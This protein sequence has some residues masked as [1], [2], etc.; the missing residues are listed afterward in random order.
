MTEK[1]AKWKKTSALADLTLAFQGFKQPN[2]F[3]LFKNHTNGIPLLTSDKL[4]TFVWIV[5]YLIRTEI[6]KYSNKIYLLTSSLDALHQHMV[7]L[8]IK[9]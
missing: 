3:C 6:I 7:L 4:S 2:T 1:E 5:W 9:L 8:L